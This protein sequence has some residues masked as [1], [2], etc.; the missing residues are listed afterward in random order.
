MTQAQTSGAWF[1]KSKAKRPIWGLRPLRSSVG[2]TLLTRHWR[3]LLKPVMFSTHPCLSRW[4]RFADSIVDE[5]LQRLLALSRNH[6][7]H[8]RLLPSGDAYNGLWHL[9]SLLRTK[10]SGLAWSVLL[11]V[12]TR[13]GNLRDVATQADRDV[14]DQC[15]R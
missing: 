4:T 13:I 14:F 1:L 12:I 11:E 10:G 9:A 3:L 5:R 6:A 7:I 8:C 15:P 2:N